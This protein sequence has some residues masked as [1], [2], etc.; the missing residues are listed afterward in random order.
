MNLREAVLR[1]RETGDYSSIL[2]HI[3]YADF[4]GIRF[5]RDPLGEGL[6]GH[7][8][9]AE[10]LIGNGRVG[11][12]HGGAI[13]ALLEFTGTFNA[14]HLSSALTIPKTISLTIEYVRQAN[15]EDTFCRAELIRQGRRVT[16]LRVMA[17][18]NDPTKLVAAA[19]AHFLTEPVEGGADQPG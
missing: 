12:L 7:L 4:L 6:I 1:A 2:P 13:G 9:F 8:P 16:N 14:L 17:Y 19:N 10:H 3:P 18:Q 11:A 15:F 5:E